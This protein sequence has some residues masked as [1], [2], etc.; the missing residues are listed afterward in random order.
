MPNFSAPRKQAD[1]Y[2]FSEA[3]PQIS[4]GVM[5]TQDAADRGPDHPETVRRNNHSPSKTDRALGFARKIQALLKKL[6]SQVVLF[7]KGCPG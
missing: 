4:H 6:A 2:L 5:T 3:A 1:L 7:I